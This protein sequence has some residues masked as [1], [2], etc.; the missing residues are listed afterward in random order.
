[1][2][3]KTKCRG[4]REDCKKKFN[5]RYLDNNIEQKNNK[6]GSKN[7][8][9]DFDITDFFTPSSIFE[10]DLE[11]SEESI[12]GFAIG[13]Q[14]GFEQSS[15]TS[16]TDI[17]NVEA[18][19]NLIEVDVIRCLQCEVQ[20]EILQEFYRNFDME[21]NYKNNECEQQGIN[22]NEENKTTQIWLSEFIN[23]FDTLIIFDTQIYSNIYSPLS[24]N[25]NVANARI[26]GRIAMLR[27]LRGLF[28]GKSSYFGD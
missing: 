6:T 13:F 22:C 12:D 18:L 24:E 17:D 8:V 27:S 1:M 28:L 16:L 25:N 5:E 19:D 11:E 14:V 23:L 21:L 26:T 7:S 3:I 9:C 20:P 4:P 15:D 2:E 10:Y